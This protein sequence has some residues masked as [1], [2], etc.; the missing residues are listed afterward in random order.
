MYTGTVGVEFEQVEDFEE[1]QWLYSNYE[2]YPCLS[3]QGSCKS[4]HQTL[5]ESTSIT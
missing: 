3:I 1:R 4:N 5:S 2:K